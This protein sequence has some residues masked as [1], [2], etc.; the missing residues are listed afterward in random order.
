[1]ESVTERFRI[2]P[3]LNLSIPH[4]QWYATTVAKFVLPVSRVC[5]ILFDVEHELR[6][7]GQYCLFPQEFELTLAK[8]ELILS[9]TQE[10]V[11][12]SNISP[13]YVRQQCC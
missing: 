5:T 8:V 4:Q 9:V 1:V 2:T 13:S 6:Q 12:Q 11:G 10:S 7:I 3:E